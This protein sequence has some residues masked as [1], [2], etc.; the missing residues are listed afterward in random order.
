MRGKSTRSTD[1]LRTIRLIEA[2]S[3]CGVSKFENNEISVEFF[4]EKPRKNLTESVVS[5]KIVENNGSI[6]DV[7]KAQA[8][9]RETRSEISQLQRKDQIMS[10]LLL[11]DPVKYEEML[12]KGELT[13]AKY[14]DLDG[15]GD[16]DGEEA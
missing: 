10:E 5:E 13:A 3:L 11:T 9:V 14:T 4:C 1:T 15:D 2:L 7:V 6:P 16:E 12:E 8:T